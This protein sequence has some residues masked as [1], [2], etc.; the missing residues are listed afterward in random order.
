MTE[1][2]GSPNSRAHTPDLRAP[3]S[4]GLG[5][6]LKTGGLQKVGEWPTHRPFIGYERGPWI[7]LVNLNSLL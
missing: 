6:S 3:M 1:L 7:T 2:P 4:W 5:R